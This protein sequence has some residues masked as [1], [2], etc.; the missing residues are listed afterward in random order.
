ML[1]SGQFLS[2]VFQFTS[3]NLDFV[4]LRIYVASVVLFLSEYFPHVQVL[5]L[6]ATYS[7]LISDFFILFSPFMSIV[8]L[9][10]EGS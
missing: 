10:L 8:L 2:I 7:G 1:C 9:T 5:S 6:T 3:S 4:Q